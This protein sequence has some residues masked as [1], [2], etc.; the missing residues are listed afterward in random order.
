MS[1][2]L[3][4]S[5]DQVVEEKVEEKSDFPFAGTFKIFDRE[6]EANFLKAMG[7]SMTQ[8]TLFGQTTIVMT[9]SGNAAGVQI[10]T[11][12]SLGFSKKAD[13][14]AKFGEKYECKS[15]S[16][17]DVTKTFVYD[18]EKKTMVVTTER[19]GGLTDTRTWTIDGDTITI[20]MVAGDEA[21][22]SG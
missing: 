6:N 17:E 7:V 4:G 15:L 10:K 20:D 19:K 11:E 14:D 1:S 18:A 22:T 2:M 8:R 21:K 3:C 12:A 9:V 16:G 5:A 13:W